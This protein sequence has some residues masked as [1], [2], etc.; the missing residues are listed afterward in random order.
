M[1]S[2]PGEL[3]GSAMTDEAYGALRAAAAVWAGTSVLITNHRGQVLVQH[4]DYLDTCLLTGVRAGSL[5][6]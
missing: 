3:P 5:R 1:P 2:V 4:V 6:G